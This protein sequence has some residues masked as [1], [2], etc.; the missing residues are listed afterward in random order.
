MESPAGILLVLFVV[1][2][3]VIVGLRRLE[4][5]KDKTTGELRSILRSAEWTFYRNALVELRE[6][7]ENIQDEVVPI[8]DLLISDSKYERIAGWLILEELFPELAARVPQF[9]RKTP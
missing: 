8:L 3:A 4:S 9:A 1:V 2:L 5:M 7:Q 6:R